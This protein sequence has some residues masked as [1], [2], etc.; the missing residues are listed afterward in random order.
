MILTHE[1][2]IQYDCPYVNRKCCGNQCMSWI[3]YKETN[4]PDAKPPSMYSDHLN[5]TPPKETYSEKGYCGIC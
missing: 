4:R 5:W 2:A 1:E 3:M